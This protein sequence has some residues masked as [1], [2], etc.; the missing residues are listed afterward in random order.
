MK[1]QP[2]VSAKLYFASTQYQVVI[3]QEDSLVFQKL[4]DNFELSKQLLD[5]F[6]SLGGSTLSSDSTLNTLEQF[7]LRL[8]RKNKITTGIK[9][10]FD[11][12]W[13]MFSKQQTDS[14]RL[15][16]RSM[17]PLKLYLFPRNTNGSQTQTNSMTQ[18]QQHFPLLQ[19]R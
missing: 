1:N 4:G 6:S 17:Y 18:L 16:P 13:K 19:N 10:L 14:Q 3:K 9:N 2:P 5:K 7:V 11:L 15:P 8:Y 12:R